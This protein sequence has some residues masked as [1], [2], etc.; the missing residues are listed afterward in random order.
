VRLRLRWKILLFTVPPLVALTFGTLWMVNRS[1]SRKV[2]VNVR[3]DLTRASAVFE[4][5]IAARTR[6]LAVAGQVIVQDPRFFSVLTLASTGQDAQLKATV[7]GVAAEFNEITAPSCSRWSIRAI[8]SSP[9]SGRVTSR[10]RAAR[11]WSS[12][13]SPDGRSPRS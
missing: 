7:K 4:D 12:R 9:R 11:A 13:R 2:Q 1:V 8:A 6:E 5:M 10:R 3:Q